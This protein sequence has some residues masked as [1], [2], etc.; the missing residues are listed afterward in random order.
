[1]SDDVA[2]VARAFERV[3]DAYE[4][5]RPGYPAEAV[6]WLSGI[7]G[8][9]PG[10]VVV[11][12]GA[13]TGKL[14]RLLVPS[15]ARVI[16]IEPGAKMLAQ[17]AHAVPGAEAIAG[18]AEAIPLPDRSAD[19][20]TVAQAFHWFRPAEAVA[21]LRR[22]LRPR[23]GLAVIWNTRDESDPLQ[24]A[25]GEVLESLRSSAP[26]RDEHDVASVLGAAG[27]FGRVEHRRFVHRQELDEASFVERFLSVSFVAA[28]PARERERVDA[29]LRQLV[30][31]APRPIAIP[32]STDVYVA[33]K[34]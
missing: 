29:R 14:T 10:R 4:R 5:G 6:E 28:A 11:D 27:G 24:R 8:L 21:E 17:L 25:V 33:F 23:G 31:N 18:T 32:Y 30:A 2:A 16:A 19:A 26:A 13:G 20:V 9:R 12:V 22:V 1:M 7:L 3:A 15:G 34:R